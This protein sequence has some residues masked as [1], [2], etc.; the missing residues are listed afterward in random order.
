MFINFFLFFF[1]ITENEISKIV[2]E[3][4]KKQMEILVEREK[5]IQENIKKHDDELL[6]RLTEAEK[7]LKSRREIIDEELS[8]RE[9]HLSKMALEWKDR[10]DEIMRISA[11]FQVVR[12]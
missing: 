2:E 9:R 4:S 10:H 5:R 1:R 12:S 11:N 8:Q 3:E 7:N 6:K